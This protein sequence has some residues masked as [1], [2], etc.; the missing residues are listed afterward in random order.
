MTDI[1]TAHTTLTDSVAAG[2]APG[3]SVSQQ[4]GGERPDAL[5]VF[6]SARYDY[7]ALLGALERTCSPKQVVGCSSAGEFTSAAQAEG[8]ACA[9]ALR[10]ADMR[11]TAAVGRG[12]RE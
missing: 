4:L 11:F 2:E 5:I 7:T 3:S 12:L 10:A 6:A 9:I 1:A 8:A